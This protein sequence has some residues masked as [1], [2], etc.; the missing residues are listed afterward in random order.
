MARNATRLQTFYFSHYGGEH[1]ETDEVASVVFDI[2]LSAVGL[3]KERVSTVSECLNEEGREGGVSE[4]VSKSVS[5][6]E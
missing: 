1:V 4:R 3:R 5:E 6:S 2:D